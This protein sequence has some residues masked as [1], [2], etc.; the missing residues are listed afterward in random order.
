M[1]LYI[2]LLA[3]LCRCN[4]LYD[5][6]PDKSRTEIDDYQGLPEIVGTL[7]GNNRYVFQLW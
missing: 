2:F 7:A 1:S 5:G 4:A 6:H 3:I